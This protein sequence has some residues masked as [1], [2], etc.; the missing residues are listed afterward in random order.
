MENIFQLYKKSTKL[1]QITVF[2]LK[3][4]INFSHTETVFL[5]NL[6]MKYTLKKNIFF[7]KVLEILVL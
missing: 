5:K 1:F 2:Y 6:H 7:S 3:F 4:K